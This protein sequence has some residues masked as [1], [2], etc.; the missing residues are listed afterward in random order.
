MSKKKSCQ[1]CGRRIKSGYIYCWEHRHHNRDFHRG[2][3]NA[4]YQNHTFGFLGGIICLIISYILFRNRNSLPN[5]MN[6]IVIGLL[7]FAFGLFYMGYVS[8]KKLNKGDAW[9]INKK[10][11]IYF[12]IFTIAIGGFLMTVFK[13]SYP[14][15]LFISYILIGIGIITILFAITSKSK[16]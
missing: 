14:N 12:G 4:L 11:F 8:W 7:I 9:R 15:G 13:S 3:K 1:V 10:N 16:R 5:D 6:Y 2:Q